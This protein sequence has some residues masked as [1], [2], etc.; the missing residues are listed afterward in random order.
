[1]FSPKN[2]GGVMRVFSVLLT[3]CFLVASFSIESSAQSRVNAF[4]GFVKVRTN[5]EL[6]VEMTPAKPG[7]PTVI[8]LNGL[9]YS[10]RQFDPFVAAL[11]ALGVG[12]V[13][14]D[15]EGMGQTLLKYAPAL[16][17]F[18]YEDQV[19]DLK[20]LLAQL[21]MQPP[22]NLAGLSYG[23]GI[24]LAYAQAYPE[25]IKTMT[26]MAPFTEALASQDQWIRSQIWLT[27]Q[28]NPINM[29]SDDQLYD[30]FLH[31]I[32]Y[33]TYPTAE[34]LVMENPFKLEAVYHLVQ[35]IRKFKAAE[36]ADKLPRGTMHMMIAGSDQYIPRTV[37]TT[38]WDRVPADVKESLVIVDHSEHKMP[39]AVPHFTA[40]W[41]YEILKGNPLLTGGRT[42]EADP[43]TGVVTYPGGQVRFPREK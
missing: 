16:R 28:I 8:L 37:L 36:I 42:F 26:L 21:N 7:F 10:T 18:P 30:F 14:Y 23:G 15:M 34:P 24:A 40:R 20:V 11:T 1:M 38:F 35:G 43:F 3:L 25:D 12:T 33:T 39:E 32:V 27:R 29:A 41:V 6:Y 17:P 9:T 31:Q 4:K 22:Y 2:K 13:R 5:T 19:R